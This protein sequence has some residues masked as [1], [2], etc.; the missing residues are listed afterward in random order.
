MKKATPTKLPNSHGMVPSE[1]T[2][3]QIAIVRDLS[4]LLPSRGHWPARS[5]VSL[6]AAAD[7]RA[8][9]EP[10]LHAGPT[11]VVDFAHARVNGSE[12]T[13]CLEDGKKKGRARRPFQIAG[14]TPQRQRQAWGRYCEGMVV[15]AVEPQLHEKLPP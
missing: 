11:A 6:S 14:K 8:C 4:M 2:P 10:I 7:T 12:R 5:S 9:P 1:V 13:G 3:S 15:P